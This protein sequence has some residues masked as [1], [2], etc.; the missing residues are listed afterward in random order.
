MDKK[1]QKNIL[2]IIS[3]NGYEI[4]DFSLVFNIKK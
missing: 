3:K 1:V 2:N 4:I